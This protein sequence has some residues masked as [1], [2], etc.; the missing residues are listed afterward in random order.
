MTSFG[1][2]SRNTYA[3]FTENKSN[4]TYLPRIKTG[5]S[6]SRQLNVNVSDVIN[7]RYD[8]NIGTLVDKYHAQDVH[9][10]RLNDYKKSINAIRQFDKRRNTTA[11]GTSK[12]KWTTTINATGLTYVAN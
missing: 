3:T 10:K 8:K 2:K 5:G 1:L 6:D 9:L 11:D 12:T 7:Y 4:A